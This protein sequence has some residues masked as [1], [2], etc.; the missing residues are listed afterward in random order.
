MNNFIRYSID[1]KNAMSGYLLWLLE[2]S[3]NRFSKEEGHDHFDARKL[4]KE[5]RSYFSKNGIRYS[6]VGKE[7]IFN[8]NSRNSILCT[9]AKGT[10]R[11]LVRHIR[12]S[13]VHN[14]LVIE[15][16]DNVEYVKA[17]D[18]K[19][20]NQ[21]ALIFVTMKAFKTI[22]RIVDNYS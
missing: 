4:G 13:I 3:G 19:R 16:I 1:N 8:N 2:D 21:S 20:G 11:D 15:T 6:F 12:N 10:V 5:L 18:G 9:P 14:S 17:I 7:F 22:L